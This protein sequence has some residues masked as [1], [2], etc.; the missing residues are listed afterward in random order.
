MLL[1]IRGAEQG[2]KGYEFGVKAAKGTDLETQAKWA[3]GSIKNNRRRYNEFLTTGFYMEN[4]R[5]IRPGG[6]DWKVG[7]DMPDFTEF[8][9]RY[10]SPTGYGYAPVDAPNMPATERK[11][12]LNWGPNVRNLMQ[13]YDKQFKDR[14]LKEVE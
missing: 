3:A 11:L 8:M 1:A 13:K 7:P 2:G 6:K 14:G 5:A 10:G 9:W 4:G 12:N